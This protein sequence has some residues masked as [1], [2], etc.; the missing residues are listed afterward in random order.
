MEELKADAGQCAECGKKASEGWFLYCVSCAD[1]ALG[2]EQE[3]QPVATVQQRAEGGV[4]AHLHHFLPIGTKLFAATPAQQA[5]PSDVPE[6]NCGDMALP[7]CECNASTDQFC[8]ACTYE[9]QWSVRAQAEAV[10]KGW[11]LVPVEPT[12]KMLFAGS[13][14]AETDAFGCKSAW[15]S[16]TYRAMLAAAPKQAEAVPQWQPIETAPKDG[17]KLLLFYTNSLGRARTVVACWVTDEEAAESDHDGF[18]LEAGWYERIDN[19]GEYSQVGI[20]EG[21][22][23]HWMPLPPPP[24]PT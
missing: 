11:K 24:Q 7:Q 18:G 23:S 13:S 1:K 15:P 17:R 16:D 22:P 2:I 8:E 9:R 12:E 10:P 19:W 4:E 5:Q 3:A 6:T 21:E 20:H 14:A